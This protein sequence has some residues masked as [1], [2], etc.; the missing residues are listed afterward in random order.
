[1]PQ[2]LKYYNTE[3]SDAP[4]K[5]TSPSI[6]SA[7]EGATSGT[8]AP[9]NSENFVER[10]ARVRLFF[11]PYFSSAHTTTPQYLNAKMTATEAYVTEHPLYAVAML[12]AA[13][14]MSYLALR[15]C[16]GDDSSHEREYGYGKEGRMD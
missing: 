12:G 13:L 11:P 8:I 9:K 4:I 16:L 14:V 3:Q 5:L 1:V 10:M 2:V 6:F 15:R 7:L